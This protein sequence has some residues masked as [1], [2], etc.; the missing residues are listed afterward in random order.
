MVQDLFLEINLVDLVIYFSYL[1]FLLCT[2]LL[3]THI[4][5]KGLLSYRECL[6][7]LSFKAMSVGHHESSLSVH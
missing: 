6:P 2:T 1:F 4:E 3:E 5:Q 7:Q